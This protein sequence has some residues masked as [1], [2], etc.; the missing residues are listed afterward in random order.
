MYKNYLI[1]AGGKIAY[2]GDDGARIPNSWIQWKGKIYYADST[3]FAVK[4]LKTIKGKTYHFHS[5]RYYLYRNK[6][7]V[8]RDG[9]IYYFGNNGARYENGLAQI[10]VD[11]LTKTYYF[12]KDGKAHKGWLTLKGKKYYFY[13]GTA[14]ASGTRAENITLTDS[15]GLVSVFDKNGVC[16]KQYTKKAGRA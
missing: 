12:H 10:K 1:T 7:S 3:G 9:N 2:V 14:M 15:K 16:I 13:K 4:G 8:D 5:T 6:R 11:G